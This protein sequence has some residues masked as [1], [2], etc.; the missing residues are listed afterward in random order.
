M[1]KIRNGLTH[2]ANKAN[3]YTYIYTIFL[4][5]RNTKPTMTIQL[6]IVKTVI[7]H[8]G[9]VIYLKILQKDSIGTYELKDIGGSKFENRPKFGT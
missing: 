4:K 1:Y 8:L 9:I 6:I 3:S 5:I 7:K 2:R